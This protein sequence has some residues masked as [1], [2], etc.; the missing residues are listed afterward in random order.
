MKKNRLIFYAVIGVLHLFVLI[1]SIYMDNKKNDTALL[2]KLYD[3]IWLLKYCSFVLLV[4]FATN[5]V[6]HL[7]DNRR[8]IRENQGLIQ[9]LNTLKAKL[10]DLQEN[11]RQKAAADE[12][13]SQQS[14]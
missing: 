1:F 12:Q 10:Y 11:D 6:L 7:R 2:F 4:F 5:I 14:K 13:A 3:K 9:E 8:H